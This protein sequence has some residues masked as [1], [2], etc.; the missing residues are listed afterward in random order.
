MQLDE[1]A[2]VQIHVGGVYG[3]KIE[4][5]ARFVRTYNTLDK[6]IRQRLFIENAIIWSVF[7][8]LRYI[9]LP[10]SLVIFN[11]FHAQDFVTL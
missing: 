2:R 4:T 1:T 8:S 6:A 11:N 9:N 7:L 3:N 10:M 5:L